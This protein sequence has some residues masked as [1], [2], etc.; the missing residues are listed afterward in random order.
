MT[1]FQVPVQ[2][3]PRPTYL[4]DGTSHSGLGP[5]LSISNQANTPQLRPQGNLMKAI[6]QLNFLFPGVAGS[7]QDS[8]PQLGKIF[9][10]ISFFCQNYLFFYQIICQI[11]TVLLCSRWLRVCVHE[12]TR[13]MYTCAVSVNINLCPLFFCL[14]EITG[15][16]SGSVSG[17]GGVQGRWEGWNKSRLI[18]DSKKEGEEGELQGRYRGNQHQQRRETQ[19]EARR[20]THNIYIVYPVSR[21]KWLCV[22]NLKLNLRGKKKFLGMLRVGEMVFLGE[23]PGWFPILNAQP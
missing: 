16:C 12:G 21:R 1:C 15:A 5:P 4:G 2:L 17:W 9:V 22:S 23:E 13:H 3:Q 11:Q 10:L 7:H 14:P 19:P 6:P 18:E 8:L 20:E